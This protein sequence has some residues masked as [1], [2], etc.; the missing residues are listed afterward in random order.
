MPTITVSPAANADDARCTTAGGAFNTTTSELILGATGASYHSAIRFPSV[1]LPA[2]AVI[3]AASIEFEAAVSSSGTVCNVTISGNDVDDA[4]QPSN[5]AD[6]NGATLTSASVAWSS[7][8]S[9]TAGS[10]YSTPNIASIIQEIYDRPGWSSG[11]AIRIQIVDNG[12]TSN[13]NRQPATYDHSTRTEPVLSIT[14]DVILDVTQ[15][16]SAAVAATGDTTI[17]GAVAPSGDAAIAATGDAATAG[18]IPADGN[19]AV[20]ASGDLTVDIP[21]LVAQDG[22]AEIAATGDVTIA[23]AI[24][25]D[26]EIT[27]TGDTAITATIP[28][29]G[30]A[31]VVASGDVALL[32]DV[33]IIAGD[34]PL[35]VTGD[36]AASLTDVD[37]HGHRLR[38]E[39]RT[40][41]DVPI[42]AGPVTDIISASYGLALD[43]VG[44]FS[45]EI[46]A[47]H[48]IAGQ[49]VSG[50]RMALYREGEGEVFRGI[51]QTPK[52]TVP[53]SGE[54]TLLVT[55]DSIAR[56]LVWANTL[57]GREY[58]NE[59]MGDVVDDLV[60]GTGWTATTDSDAR[61]L[62]AAFDAASIWRATAH[63]AEMFGWHVREDNL[64][65]TL[66]VGA[67]GADSG[68]I[69]QNVTQAEPEM[70]IIPIRSLSLSSEQADLWNHV[71]P[72]GGG[73]GV[74]VLTLRYSTRST[75]Y[76]IQSATGPDGQTYW[77]IEDATSI[78]THGERVMPLSFPDVVPLSNSDAE[79][80]NAANALYDI[81]SAWLGWHATTHEVY[82]VE[83]AGLHHYDDGT[84][85]ITVGDT[86]R[87]VY[88]GLALSD[89]GETIVW[90]DIDDDVYV[91]GFERSFSASDLNGWQLTVST[92][93]K[94]APGDAQ[95]IAQAIDDLWA[96]QTSKRPYTY[97]EIHGPFVESIDGSNTA[98]FLVDFD[99]N[100]TYLHSATLRVR[101][102]R[103]KSNVSSAASG[104]GQTSSSGGGQTTSSGGGQ[105]SSGGTA[106]THT[107]SGQTTGSGGIHYHQV[108]Q[109]FGA[110][111]SWSDPSHIQQMIMYTSPTGPGN[112][113]GYYVGRGS[114]TGGT[115]TLS[116]L[117]TTNH[118]HSVAGQ[119]S[120]AESAHT[121]TISNHTHTVSN[122]THTVAD[123]THALVYGIYL[124]PTAA[125]PSINLSINGSNR[126]SAL[127]G[128]W[129]SD[130]SVDITPYLVDGNGHVLRQANN[131]DF[132]GAQLCD[133]EITVRSMVTA[134][135]IVPV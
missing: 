65:R 43:E 90:K 41:A 113:H 102:R 27:A 117:E 114:G 15:D 76:T 91:L 83:I 124:G 119:T 17:T 11:N 28:Q 2:G 44:T 80:R 55:G 120:S 4:G 58:S 22:D 134:H 46:P 88:R 59:P 77:Y 39:F 31:E 26:A 86:V 84:A 115:E 12:S 74:N 96:V 106:H 24:S 23:P 6:I 56:E 112:E 5:A 109:V 21:V 63:A 92:S 30:D 78:S 64:T 127:G 29:T 104:G 71:V 108:G 18:T 122:H 66:D 16:G 19:A 94:Q 49:I 89:D 121:H 32:A 10:L 53:E 9:W 97:R 107:V 98:R 110:P 7:L 70:A 95:A 105:T 128:P 125:A 123:H 47:A 75:P 131:L 3:T 45:I 135:S 1:A 81:A 37:I 101:K 67:F 87:L 68:L 118:T 116:T 38:A 50:C 73:D 54:Y 42:G 100:V 85:L 25:A 14:Y 79:I 52:I 93:S 61:N 62:T 34:V 33:P 8:P 130:F 72:L 40:A 69:L 20:A 132:S 103:V 36:L 35:A 60:T 126:T 51:V 99:A 48:P 13:A 82:T 133:L 111:S 129:N 57:F